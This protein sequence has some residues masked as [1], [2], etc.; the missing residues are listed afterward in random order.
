[1]LPV[2][3]IFQAQALPSLHL[4]P[5]ASQSSKNSLVAR[6]LSCPA[7]V[8]KTL[9]SAHIRQSMEFQLGIQLHAEETMILKWS[10]HEANTKKYSISLTIKDAHIEYTLFQA[11]SGKTYNVIEYIN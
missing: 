10:N 6:A 5:F 11:L 2:K 9:C 1:M 3:L 4:R 8:G 7:L